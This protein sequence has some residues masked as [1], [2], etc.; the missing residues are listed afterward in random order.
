VGFVDHGDVDKTHHHHGID[1]ANHAI[2]ARQAIFRNFL[3]AGSSR[4]LF[5]RSS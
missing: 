2:P 1:D 5:W 3:A 4:L